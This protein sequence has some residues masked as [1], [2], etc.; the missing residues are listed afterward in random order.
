M[1]DK[2]QLIDTNNKVTEILILSLYLISTILTSLLLY[3]FCNGSLFVSLFVAKY[4]LLVFTSFL[5]IVVL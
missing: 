3:I 5:L 1:M 4:F 2:G